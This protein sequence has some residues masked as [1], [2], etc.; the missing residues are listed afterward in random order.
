MLSRLWHARCRS[1]QSSQR[2]RL[3]ISIRRSYLT[4]CRD[5]NV[6]E[7]INGE[8]FFGTKSTHRVQQAVADYQAPTTNFLRWVA[9]C[10]MCPVTDTGVSL[11]RRIQSRLLGPMRLLFGDPLLSPEVSKDLDT[12]IRLRGAVCTWYGNLQAA[13][14]DDRVSLSSWQSAILEKDSGNHVFFLE[15]LQGAKKL[16]EPYESTVDLCEF[17][18]LDN[19]VPCLSGTTRRSAA[20]AEIEKAGSVEESRKHAHESSQEDASAMRSEADP[21]MEG[22]HSTNDDSAFEASGLEAITTWILDLPEI[23]ATFCNKAP[24]QDEHLE[25]PLIALS[26]YPGH[27]AQA[28]HFEDA[29]AKE[30][31][32]PTRSKTQKKRDKR[33]RQAKY[34]RDAD[35]AICQPTPAP[36]SSLPQ[37][38]SPYAAPA[39]RTRDDVD[40]TEVDGLIST[41]LSN[42]DNEIVNPARWIRVRAAA[43]AHRRK[44]EGLVNSARKLPSSSWDREKF[45]EVL[46]RTCRGQVA[47]MI[48]TGERFIDVPGWVR[49]AEMTYLFKD[50]RLL[51]LLKRHNA[52]GSIMSP[53]DSEISRTSATGMLEELRRSALL[54]GF[55]E[56]SGGIRDQLRDSILQ[57]EIVCDWF[58]SLPPA[59]SETDHWKLDTA[60]N[61]EFVSTLRSM[62]DF[63]GERGT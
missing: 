28:S 52:T 51:D 29:L 49:D 50:A 14:R 30:E 10:V 23:D 59:T 1:T 6:I 55:D 24:T 38:E 9:G 35:I 16:L 12:A 22:S 7:V 61:R 56:I 31:S 25:L 27:G 60:G 58:D 11:L 34:K 13:I 2:S 8:V 53:G 18:P 45:E 19:K 20:L 41:I 32:H 39:L 63:I 36:L 33:K 5:L 37:S 3:D 21:S 54:G 40:Y 57:R 4:F 46:A 17:T 44:L 48:H 42:L 15:L 47:K 62:V 43:L 26:A